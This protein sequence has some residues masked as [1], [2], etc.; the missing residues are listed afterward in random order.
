M[1]PRR[2]HGLVA[3]VSLLGL[4][5]P[6]AATA[7]ASP[8]FTVTDLGSIEASASPAFGTDPA[9]RSV[10]HSADGS[11]AYE[12]KPLGPANGVSEGLPHMMQA[13]IDSQWTYGNP[14]YAYDWILNSAANHHGLTASLEVVG[15]DGHYSDR[16][17]AVFVERRGEDGRWELLAQVA[18]SRSATSTR[19]DSGGL[20]IAGINDRDQVL[21]AKAGDWSAST[22]FLYDAKLGTTTDLSGILGTGYLGVYAAALDADGRLLLTTQDLTGG[23]GMRELLLTPSDLSAA[24]IPEPSTW[25]VLGLA[26][27]A[28]AW[29]R[30]R[31]VP[32]A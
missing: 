14:A 25:M 7:S 26:G 17:A 15:V 8:S 21:V 18:D 2:R 3:F 4:A 10:V 9:G 29:R 20:W 11:S 1:S 6:Q 22:A 12:F 16:H 28:I 27:A 5:A 23:G 31:A 24:P 32:P 13:P 19:P 30:L